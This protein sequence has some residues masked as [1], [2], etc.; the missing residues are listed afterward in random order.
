MAE[1]G[2]GGTM[3]ALQEHTI[4]DTAIPVEQT[5]YLPDIQEAEKAF[6]ESRHPLAHINPFWHSA[7]LE[8]VQQSERPTVPGP[9]NPLDQM[10]P[11][12]E[13]HLSGPLAAFEQPT[14]PEIV[15]S[16]EHVPSEDQASLEE[17]QG[18]AGLSQSAD[19]L[20]KN[21]ASVHMTGMDQVSPSHA[22][23]FSQGDHELETATSTSQALSAEYVNTTEP[24]SSAEIPHPM[25]TSAV[26][27]NGPSEHTH[28]SQIPPTSDMVDQE[29]H[30]NTTEGDQDPFSAETWQ[31]ANP[32]DGQ[33][34]IGRTLDVDSSDADSALGS[35]TSSLTTSISSSITDYRFEH[36]R[37]YHAFH[38]GAYY[39]PNDEIETD[40]LDLQ[41]HV[42][43]MTLNGALY[44]APISD[45]I[46]NVLDIG[47]GTGIWAIE[48]A[49]EHPSVQ[50]V[51]VDLSP[52]QPAFVPPNC[53]FIIDNAEEDWVYD[54]KF[55]FIHARML[56]LGMHDWPR[57]FR[58]SWD[59]MKP[60]AWLE[61]QEL[62][63][64]CRSDDGSASR[65]S[66]FIDWSYR[67]MEAAGKVGIDPIACEKFEEQLAHQGF[68]NIKYETIK[69]P[70]GSWA[71]GKKEKE[72]G[73]WM[74]ENTLQAL[75]GLTMALLTRHLG[76]SREAV[77]LFLVGVRKQ[78]LDRSSHVYVDV[79]VVLGQKPFHA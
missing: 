13:N 7:P 64:P 30:M 67:L 1:Q 41:H 17:P 37:R 28:P 45:S 34:P 57:F 52:I 59:Y 9:G 39:L 44:L 75:Q 24:Q 48:F 49:Q 63:F 46:T 74:M 22:T 68:V 72:I 35:D 18:A 40:R 70:I 62:Q 4:L 29:Y 60:G 58:Q 8:P 54:K 77:E 36:G 21:G 50:V 14:F 42:W 26:E 78:I 3:E 47:T 6:P 79:R 71:K 12:E 32:W 53:S 65:E 33:V 23:L 25:D 66:P 51:G 55:D 19:I 20:A 43:R 38:D 5:K 56:V 73:R 76:W 31:Q 16:S 61:M 15:D 27:S 11:L 2:N 10:K 69:W